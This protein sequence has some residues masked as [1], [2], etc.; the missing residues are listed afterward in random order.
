MPQSG[1][2]DGFT[3]LGGG[4]LDTWVKEVHAKTP[5]AIEGYIYDQ[6]ELV[7]KDFFLRTKA[8]RDFLG[9]LF[10]IADIG[11]ISLNPVDADSNVIMV[12]EVTRNGIPLAHSN[13]A[14]FTRN[15]ANTSNS[16]TPTAYYTNP[17]HT[18]HL[19]PTPVVDVEN[20]Y[21]SV[22]LIPRLTSDHRIQDWVV[23]QHYEPI[24]AGILQRMYQE[25]AKVYTNVTLAEYWGKKYR[26]E[27]ARA[28]AVA[29]QN[30]Q[31]SPHPWSYPT[32]SR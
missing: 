31:T 27:L 8:W 21:V 15:Y 5:G 4:S 32:W 1:F 11:T 18:I 23:D 6:T 22:A 26:A 30:Y 16:H 24:L 20:I 9:P 17:Y 25:P 13:P 7:I 28:T 12:L 2:E 29:D 3:S 19:V 14:A 10:A